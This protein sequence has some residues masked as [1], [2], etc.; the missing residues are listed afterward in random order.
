M[1]EPHVYGIHHGK[2]QLLTFQVAGE[3]SSGSIPNWRR[4]DLDDVSD[5]TLL[6]EHFAGPRPFPSGKHSK[7]DHVIV[8]VK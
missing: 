8:F 1:A 3:S 7:F 2:P 4:V 6:G 5:L